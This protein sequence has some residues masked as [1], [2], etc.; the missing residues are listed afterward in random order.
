MS[1]AQRTATA[2]SIVTARPRVGAPRVS[3]AWLTKPFSLAGR[4]LLDSRE[5]PR[6]YPREGFPE[7]E[8]H[9]LIAGH[10]DRFDGFA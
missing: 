10:R 1:V 4:W 7:I 9:Q 3:A 8:L 2:G 6:G 5:G